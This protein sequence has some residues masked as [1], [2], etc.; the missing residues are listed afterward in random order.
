[1]PPLAALVQVYF[2]P[3]RAA[4]TEAMWAMDTLSGK[5]KL[6]PGWRLTPGQKIGRRVPTGVAV[7]ALAALVVLA[8]GFGFAY[9]WFLGDLEFFGGLE[10]GWYWYMVNGMWTMVIAFIV[11]FGRLARSIQERGVKRDDVQ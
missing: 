8:M 11:P 2:A 7:F 6:T 9:A 1:L 3:G 4:L 10:S 5:F